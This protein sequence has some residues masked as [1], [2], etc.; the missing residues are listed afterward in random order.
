MANIKEYLKE[1]YIMI[2]VFIFFIVAIFILNGLGYL[3][4]ENDGKPTDK[5]FLKNNNI[6]QE[7]VRREK[8]KLPVNFDK[9]IYKNISGVFNTLVYHYE[10]KPLY[11]NEFLV[12]S[13][14]FESD[15]IGNVC[16]NESMHPVLNAKINL[17]YEYSEA[18]G[19]ILKRINVN[20]DICSK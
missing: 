17:I 5:E 11:V 7:A 9:M 12:N 18:N 10:I 14:K 19:N 20:K 15:L 6:V 1:N 2:G 4:I 13:D 16:S 8:V 3:S